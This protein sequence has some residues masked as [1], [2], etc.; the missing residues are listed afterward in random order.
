MLG[1]EALHG[2]LSA[3]V[4][5]E[6]VGRGK[7]WEITRGAAICAPPGLQGRRSL[8][9]GCKGERE[10]AQPCVGSGG[11]VEIINGGG[12]RLSSGVFGERC[13]S[14]PG[15]LFGEKNPT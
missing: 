1:G 12:P 14:F 13:A 3:C 11:C 7:R 9:L 6:A 5:A 2:M 10:K 4:R 8:V 15:L